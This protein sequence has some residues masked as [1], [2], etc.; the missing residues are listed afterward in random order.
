MSP[1]APK[2][3][4]SAAELRRWLARNGGKERELWLLFFRKGSGRKSVTYPEALDEAL[5][6][7]WIDGVRRRVDDVSYTQRFSPR[8]KDSFW[9]AV[10]TRRAK[11]LIAAGRM[12]PGGLAAFE[13][14][15]ESRTANFARERDA[16]RL[17]P[18]E[19]RLFR[20]TPGAWE[21]FTSLSPSLQR[22]S[23]WWV[24]SAKS[25]ETRRRRLLDLVRRSAARRPRGKGPARAR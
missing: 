14:R 17:A 16:A 4:R 11:E 9:S 22:T 18:A 7:G 15:D 12:T 3:F 23:T 10:N 19:V 2:P 20:G 13:G 24:V 25:R 1:A 6:H 8:R 21:G 5:C